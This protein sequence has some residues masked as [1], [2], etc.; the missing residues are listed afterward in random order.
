MYK[1]VFTFFDACEYISVCYC[2]TG[3]LDID[4][5]TRQSLGSNSG[6]GNIMNDDSNFSFPGDMK[7]E[8]SNDTNMSAG[9]G[10]T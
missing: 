8:D 5:T 1:S 4:D 9:N 6:S 3:S 2:C 7:Q 10:T